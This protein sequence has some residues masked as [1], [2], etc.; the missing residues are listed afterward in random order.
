M[1]GNGCLRTCD[2]SDC[3][4]HWANKKGYCPKCR[5]EI[6]SGP[7]WCGCLPPGEE[8]QRVADLATIAAE[9]EA[10]RQTRERLKAVEGERDTWKQGAEAE[11][12]NSE[13]WK[14]AEFRTQA[15]LR[16]AESERD[17]LK[18]ELA[19]TQAQLDA[20]NEVANRWTEIAG[21]ERERAERAEAA[22]AEAQHRLAC[23]APVIN[24]LRC[25]ADPE[26]IVDASY[27]DI[28]R[29]R[30]AQMNAGIDPGW[31]NEM[32][33][34]KE[35]LAAEVKKREEAQDHARQLQK[36]V[37]DNAQLAHKRTENLKI[38]Y[39]ELERKREA[40]ESALREKEEQVK[41]MVEKVEKM[42]GI[43][44]NRIE[45]G[46]CANCHAGVDATPGDDGNWS[47]WYHRGVGYGLLCGN[48]QWRSFLYVLDGEA[49]TAKPQEKPND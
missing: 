14:E 23:E 16:A 39:Q 20:M 12:E 49:L 10:H 40:A 5:R 45:R 34:W 33:A 36:L 24:W 42:R 17:A 18:A 35:A 2:C 26:D 32:D 25:G 13:A 29:E 11:A 30:I 8:A 3:M 48:S 7:D 41:A 21:K 6:A 4:R 46:D 9:Q 37:W 38:E 27:W 31:K 22:L 43:F 28:A 1:A 44:L 15:K 19:K 47:Y